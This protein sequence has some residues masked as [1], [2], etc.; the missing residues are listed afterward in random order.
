MKIIHY[1]TVA[2]ITEYPLLLKTAQ[3]NNLSENTFL[4]CPLSWRKSLQKPFSHIRQIINTE[5]DRQTPL[6]VRALKCG[7]KYKFTQRHFYS[8]VHSIACQHILL[9][10]L[11]RR[12]D[13][14]SSCTFKTLCQ[15]L[16]SEAAGGDLSSAPS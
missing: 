9:V 15:L 16:L 4:F 2:A 6:H 13:Q 10:T 5:P 1:T 7:I 3:N 12:Q 8:T 11:L 14:M